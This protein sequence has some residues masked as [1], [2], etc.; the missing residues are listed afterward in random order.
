MT[1]ID[2][3]LLVEILHRIGRIEFRTLVISRVVGA[4]IW[5]LRGVVPSRHT[6]RLMWIQW[7]HQPEQVYKLYFLKPLVAYS[8]QESASIKLRA[9]V[10]RRP[11]GS[12]RIAIT[13]LVITQKRIDRVQHSLH[14]RVGNIR[15]LTHDQKAAQALPVQVVE[16]SIYHFQTVFSKSTTFATFLSDVSASLVCRM[17]S[18]DC[19]LAWPTLCPLAV[20]IVIKCSYYFHRSLARARG[21]ERQTRLRSAFN[22]YTMSDNLTVTLWPSSDVI[23]IH[24]HRARPMAFKRYFLCFLSRFPRLLVW[25]CQT[26]FLSIKYMATFLMSWVELHLRLSS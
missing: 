10:S 14:R 21:F 12:H 3:S 24:K 22:V 26:Y 11:A 7:R 5:I 13:A 17:L 4:S 18:P 6:L 15:A 20:S 23:C 1:A 16:S 25:I 19:V 2:R 9:T 8:P